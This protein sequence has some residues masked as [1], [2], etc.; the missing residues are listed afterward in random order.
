MKFFSFAL[1]IDLC[2]PIG[3][4]EPKLTQLFYDIMNDI[5]AEA[6]KPFE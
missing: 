1:Q 5:T 6:K 4:I 3:S 2:C